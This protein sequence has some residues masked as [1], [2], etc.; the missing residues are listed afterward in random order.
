MRVT[1][2]RSSANRPLGAAF[3]LAAGLVCGASP[4]A[5]ASLHVTWA[6]NTEADL[7]GYRLRYGTS[8]GTYTETIEAGPANGCEVAGLQPGVLYHLAV[9][10]YDEAG[11]ESAPSAEITARIPP[12]LA[13]I[14]VVEGAAEAGSRSIYLVRA[15]TS[16]ATVYGGAFQADASVDAGPG[17][18][19]GRAVLT[20]AGT[21]LVPLDVAPSAAL[22]GRTV[23]VTNPDQGT[24]SRTD[25]LS[26][27]KIP[28]I[29]ADCA[30]DVLDL[31]ALARGW[32]ESGE[33]ARYIPEADFDGDSYIGPDDLTVFVQY[34]GRTF[35]GCP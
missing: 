29:N 34:F 1:P 12:S 3:A 17:V 15:R 30:V 35:P 9:F 11:N 21:L 31:N 14:P 2:H 20:T 10:A 32:N 16:F 28:D 26:V 6:S 19:A 5:A 25:A 27:V 7:A 13:P 33:E 22:G 8:A 4:C 23:T 18:T 24:G